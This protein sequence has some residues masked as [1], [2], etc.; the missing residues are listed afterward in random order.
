MDKKFKEDLLSEF[1][2][3]KKKRSYVRPPES[4]WTDLHR[5]FYGRDRVSKRSPETPNS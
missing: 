5:E 2:V 1:R 3:H 4:E